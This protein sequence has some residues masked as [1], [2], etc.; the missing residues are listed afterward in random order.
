MLAP[1]AETPQLRG[2]KQ[3][4]QLHAPRN[5]S[6]RPS[7]ISLREA[8]RHSGRRYEWRRCRTVQLATRFNRG[9]TAPGFS[10]FSALKLGSE[11][12]SGS[13]HC[14]AEQ[15]KRSSKTHIK[16]CPRPFYRP[17][18]HPVPMSC[19]AV[20][21]YLRTLPISSLNVASALDINQLGSAIMPS[22]SVIL[23]IKRS[24]YIACLVND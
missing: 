19:P 23:C 10:I 16:Q 1:D 15:M 13:S 8:D 22:V 11:R 24:A 3:T 6:Y 14:Q 5:N 7:L 17:L 12:H 18:Q 20:A 21:H 9:D 4:L 2:S